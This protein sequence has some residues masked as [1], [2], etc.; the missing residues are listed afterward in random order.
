[1]RSLI[2]SVVSFMFISLALQVLY[3]AFAAA[4]YDTVILL[5]DMVT[6]SLLTYILSEVLNVKRAIKN[7]KG[8]TLESDKPVTI[9]LSNVGTGSIDKG[10]H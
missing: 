7:R 8:I 5:P 10:V 9:S 1:M 4:G 2:Q 6:C 3:F